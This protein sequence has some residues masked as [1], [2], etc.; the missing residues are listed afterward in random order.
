[1]TYCLAMNVNEGLVLCSDSR[2]SAGTDNVSVYPK[3]FTFAW[4]GVR[5]FTLLS[6]CNLAT[7]QAVVKK[8]TSDIPAGTVPNLTT[9]T[10]MQEVADYVGMVSTQL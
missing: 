5:F 10:S 8:L 7:T 9:V 4:P 3:M 1:M 6:A 2:T